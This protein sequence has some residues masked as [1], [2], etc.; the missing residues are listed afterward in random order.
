[1]NQRIFPNINNL[2]SVLI[3]ELEDND[4]S[5]FYRIQIDFILFYSPSHFLE[6]NNFC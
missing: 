4:K 3:E 2:F 5:Y 6:E 1:M